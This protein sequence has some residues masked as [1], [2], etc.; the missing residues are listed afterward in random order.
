MI[1]TDFGVAR[2]IGYVAVI[3]ALGLTHLSA[4][5]FGADTIR[6]QWGKDT[7]ERNALAL[8]QEQEARAKE[9]ALAVAKQQ[10][11]VKYEQ[12]KRRRTAAAVA[13]NDELDRLRNAIR[14]HATAGLAGLG[15]ETPAA[16]PRIDGGTGLEHQLL[17]H[18]AGTLVQLAQAAD[19]QEARIVGLQSYI[20]DV[21]MK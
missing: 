18:C 3:A 5:K 13:A 10:V 14:V 15:S 11:E 9:Q 7:A 20:K 19:I 4:Y 21:C 16:C 8:Q 6:A 2:V 12:E 17:G 1:Y